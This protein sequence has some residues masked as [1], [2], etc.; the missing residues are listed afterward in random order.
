MTPAVELLEGLSY[1]RGAPR[2]LDLVSVLPST[3]HHALELVEG[4]DA[5]SALHLHEQLE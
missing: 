2:P 1:R 4:L 3:L 5:P